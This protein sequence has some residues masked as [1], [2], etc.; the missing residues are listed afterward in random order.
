VT[1]LQHRAAAIA[2]LLLLLLL[3]FGSAMAAEPSLRGEWRPLAPADGAHSA[4]VAFDPA[5]LNRIPRQPAGAELRLWIEPGDWPDQPMLLVVRRPA[6][7]RF[8][9]TPPDGGV[10]VRASTLLGSRDGWQGHGRIGFEL[11]AR[12]DRA[13]PL[14]LLIEPQQRINGT[15]AFALQS[16]TVF[17]A[18]DARWLGLVSTCLAL[19]AGMAVI[20]LVFALRLRDPAFLFYALYLLSYTMI[21]LIQTGYVASP[22]GWTGAADSAGAWGRAAVVLSVVMAALFLSRFA[23]LDRYLPRGNHLLVGYALLVSLNAAIGFLPFEWAQ[24]L[25]RALIN[26][27]L[28]LGGPLLLMLS[29]LAWRHGSRYAGFFAIGWTPL[30]LVTVAESMQL[31]G[32]WSNWLWSGETALVAAGFEALVL[33]AG[34]ADRAASVR[35]D[36]DVARALADI[37]PLT[38]VL[39]R[40]S[41]MQAFERLLADP[42]ARPLAVLFCD[43]DHFKHVNDTHG[44]VAGDRALQRTAV[45]LSADLRPSDVIGRY[46]GEEFL[47]LLPAC[48]ADAARR[49]AE[50]LRQ[51]IDGAVGF[52]ITVSI[53]L[54]VRAGGESQEAL[55]QRADRALYEAKR[56]GRNRVAEEVATA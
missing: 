26:P 54:A 15:I 21:Q 16:R 17:Q 28:I 35:R 37:D 45:A 29:V 3:L 38:G 56:Q 4:W 2:G 11:N 19:L 5:R 32:F 7:E 39:N 25:A 20:A 36:R 23:A 48:Q 22:L 50:R 30:L 55:L 34:L 44:H 9:W 31:Y 12:P 52:D 14:T 47:L 42:R 43:L 33:S 40:R 10:P 18:D 24:G 46:G 51:R 13:Q 49:I 41:L 8:V 1:A 27:L 53:G 6:L